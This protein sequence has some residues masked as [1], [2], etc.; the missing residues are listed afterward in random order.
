[1]GSD[2]MASPPPAVHHPPAVAPYFPPPTYPPPV[3]QGR[4]V[5]DGRAAAALVLAIL[6]LIFSI[7]AGLPGMVAGPI[8]YFL[9]KSARTRIRESNGAL[10]GEGAANAGRILGIVATIVGCLVGLGWLIVIFNALLDV[11]IGQ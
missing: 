9:G 8:A 11:P 5:T 10:G 2:A 1:M 7:P 6:G 4:Q 3:Q